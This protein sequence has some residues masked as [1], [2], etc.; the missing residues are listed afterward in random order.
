MSGNVLGGS[1]Y[2]NIT[3]S[4]PLLVSPP[5][6]FQRQFLQRVEEREP[7]GT[8]LSIGYPWL[9]I[10]ALNWLEYSACECTYLCK[11]KPLCEQQRFFDLT[12]A[13]HYGEIVGR[14]FL[15]IAL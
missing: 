15:I 1:A 4:F 12:C 11:E 8:V 2:P 5:L 6:L 10:T 13:N 7:Y 9:Y 3:P 14:V